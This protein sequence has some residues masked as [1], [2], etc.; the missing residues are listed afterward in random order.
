MR[1]VDLSDSWVIAIETE[2]TFVSFLLDA[3]LAPE[4]P[5]YSP[6]ASGQHRASARLRWRLTGQVHWNEGPNL[7]RVALDAS[8]DVGYG[9]I[10][11]WIGL[12]DNEMLEGAWGNVVVYGVVQE[13]EYIDAKT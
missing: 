2:P 3:C 6:P 13:V 1:H 10:D 11:S 9:T 12:G 8:T 4:H 5:H 7:E